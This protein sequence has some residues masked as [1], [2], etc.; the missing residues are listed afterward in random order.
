MKVRREDQTKLGTLSL[1]EQ[2]AIESQAWDEWALQPEVQKSI[3]S[4]GGG[5]IHPGLQISQEMK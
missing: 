3:H 1:G 5:K 2:A 4:L